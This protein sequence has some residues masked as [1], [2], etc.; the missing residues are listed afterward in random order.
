[1][2]Q[3]HLLAVLMAADVPTF[4]VQKTPGFR[5]GLL[6][7]SQVSWSIDVAMSS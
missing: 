1:M 5:P 7:A 2:R 6:G 4:C 3:R